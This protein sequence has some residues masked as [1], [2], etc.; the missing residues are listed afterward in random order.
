MLNS[1]LVK[2]NPLF[3]LDDLIKINIFI[4]IRPFCVF[5]KYY[6][7]YYLYTLLNLIE[8]IL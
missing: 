5:L 8:S 3:L 7:K 2:S 1:G 4:I 6:E